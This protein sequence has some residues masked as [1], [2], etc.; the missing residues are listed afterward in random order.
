MAEDYDLYLR[1]ARAGVAI[2]EVD[3]EHVSY[4]KHPGATTSRRREGTPG[5]ATP[6]TPARPAPTRLDLRQAGRPWQRRPRRAWRR[7]VPPPA[8]AGR[9]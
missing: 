6:A 7:G 1:M 3:E 2:R 5:M 4:R 9:A 8:E